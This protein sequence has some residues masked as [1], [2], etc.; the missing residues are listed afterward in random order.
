MRRLTLDYDGNLKLYS[1]DVTDGSWLVSLMAFPRT[2]EIHGLCGIN[3]LCTYIPKLECSCIEGFEMIEPGDWSKG[4]MSK[5]NMSTKMKRSKGSKGMVNSMANKK[6][7]FRKL[8]G[9]DFW[10]YDFSYTKSLTLFE[11]RN[12]CLGIQNCQAFGYRRG[13]GEFFPKALLFNGKTFASP[14][15]DIYLKVPNVSLSSPE[16]DSRKTH[17]CKITEEVAYPSSP[18]LGG[19][20]SKFKFDYFLS[21]ALTLLV[22]EVVL[23]VAGCWVVYKYGREDQRLQMKAI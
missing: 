10:G 9:T 6:F 7:S 20:T 23:I 15:N 5:S 21:S 11:C 4:C 1:L 3:S 18:M 14:P 8:G 12:V 22:I 17:Q 19:T 13:K 16:L 2:C